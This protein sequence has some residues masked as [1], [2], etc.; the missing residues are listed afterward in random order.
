MH[1]LVVRGGTVVDGGGG[2]PFTGDVAV[3]AGVITAVGRVDERGRR[4]IDADGALVTP[5]FVDVH[6]HYDGQA[7]WD[8]NLA[9][10]SW[11]GVTTV[12]MGNCGVGFAPVRSSDQDTLIQ[13]MEGVED[14]PGAAL[15]EGISWDWE[16]FG[17]YL[18][19]L[20]R[21]ARDVDVC[22][23]V[24]HGAVRLYVMGERGAAREPATPEEIVEM[25]RIVRDGVAAGAFGFSTSR[26]LNHRTSTGDRTPTIGAAADE[27][28]GIAR[29]MRETG[30]GA[31]EVVSDFDDLDEEFDAFAR[32]AAE[33]GAPTFIS[34]NQNKRGGH[35]RVLDRVA[36]A[37]ARGLPVRAQVAVRAIGV[38]LGLDTSLDPFVLNPAWRPYRG[39]G[40]AERLAAVADPDVRR[41]LAEAADAEPGHVF[42]RYDRFYPLADPPDYEPGP[43]ASVAAVAA[44]EGRHPVDVLCD[45]LA[46]D[47]GRGL[48][49]YPI[50]NYDE[51]DLAEQGDLLAHPDTIIGLGDGGAHVGT[52][53]DGSFPTTLLTLWGRDR[54]RGPRLE[55]PWLVKAQT[56]DTADAYGLADRG[57][58]R[59]G[60][61]ADLNVIDFAR[62]QARRPEIRHDLPA[63]GRRFIQRAEGYVATIV[64][65]EPTYRD[66]EPT[67]A[68]PGRL[69]RSG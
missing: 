65:G 1:D 23:L 56:A 17:G 18:D 27:L 43:E 20:A 29:A 38:L 69:V 54:T 55:L 61:R 21:G 39:A 33:T 57:R 63:G 40:F 10:S 64:A 8:S 47:G 36:A 31:F 11:H 59:V 58:I 3:D 60:L 35:R 22:A 52:I 66:G 32:V 51:G 41:V 9:P 34:L 46:A 12:V 16:S 25:G 44:R 24:P 50:F 48:V 45:L 15:H 26:T 4:E 53:C 7:T 30:R 62:L 42:G 68:L 2:E 28:V 67:G 19:V 6:A 14:I 13:L 49:Y 37:A 5:G